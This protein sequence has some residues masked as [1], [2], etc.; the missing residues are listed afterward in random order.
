MQKDYLKYCTSNSSNAF[1]FLCVLLCLRTFPLPV[2]RPLLQLGDSS[3][4][5][6]VD[7]VNEYKLYSALLDE[8]LPTCFIENLI[9]S[10]LNL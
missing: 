9:K 6:R 8:K 2:R 4:N 5:G 3:S 1:F 10:Q 7:S